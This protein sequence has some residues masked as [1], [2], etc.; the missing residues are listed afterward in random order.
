MVGLSPE[1]RSQLGRLL[2]SLRRR[3]PK[4]CVE[5]GRPFEGLGFQL[6]CSPRCQGRAQWRAYYRRHRD[7]VLA[8]QRERRRQR[9]AQR[10]G[11]DGR[12]PIGP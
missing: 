5:C 11:D 3:H 1:E 9:Q 2:V 8:R 10:K 6:Y 12:P 7:E 4:V